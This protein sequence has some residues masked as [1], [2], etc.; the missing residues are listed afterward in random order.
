MLKTICELIN[1]LRDY[2]SVKDSIGILAKLDE[3]EHMAGKM[4]DRLLEYCNAI[5][6]LGF[7]RIGR[8][9]ENQ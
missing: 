7:Q 5:E 9:Y 4:E 6:N 2:G 8:N 3:I 1:D